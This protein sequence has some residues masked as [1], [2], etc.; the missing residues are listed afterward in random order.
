[1]K[2]LGVHGS[3][4]K[5]GSYSLLQEALDGVREAGADSALLDLNNYTIEHC[6]GCDSCLKELSCVQEDELETAASRLTAADGLIF[7]APS[8]FGSVP[9]S[10][11]NFMDRT[12]YLKMKDHQL[13][14]RP[15]AALSSSGLK[16]GGGEHVISSLH[17]Y[18]IL[19]GMIVLGGLGDP[20]VQPN[21]VIGTRKT[22]A[23]FRKVSE[24]EEALTLARSLGKRMVNIT[25]KLG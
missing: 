21:N 18:A 19:Q 17:Y 14:N 3:P 10:M 2:I 12:R 20:R 22:E 5:R 15:F 8:H 25:K 24:D 11:K 16:H 4:V 9:A 7:S 6:Q 23:G 1:M 13:Q